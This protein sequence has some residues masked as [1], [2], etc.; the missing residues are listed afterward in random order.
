MSRIVRSPSR[1]GFVGV[2]ALVAVLLAPASAFAA[3]A[4]GHTGSPGAWG[5]TDR[6]AE[7][8][9]KCSYAGGGT[10]GTEHLTGI[11]LL[12]GPGITGIHSG[13]RSVGYQPII[14]KWHGGAWVNVKKGTL[15]TGQAS[16]HHTA[17][18]PPE[19]TAFP[20]SSSSATK[21]RLVLKLFWYHLDAS[22][23][24]T[25]RIVMDS[26]VRLSGGIGSSC[27]GQVITAD[28]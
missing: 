4:I 21:Y 15:V 19:R 23:E 13:L 9:A 14:Q 6:A 17:F 20:P 3:H 12:H 28:H 5:I 8:G 24:A 10:A 1:A 2:I 27:Q 25:E 11:K 7:P 16:T 22:V 18:L 26:Y